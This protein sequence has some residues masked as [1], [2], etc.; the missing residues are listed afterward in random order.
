MSCKHEHKHVNIVPLVPLPIVRAALIVHKIIAMIAFSGR[1]VR[2]VPCVSRGY[3][4]SP[5]GVVC[6]V[7]SLLREVYGMGGN[8][9]GWRWRQDQ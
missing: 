6:P 3:C 7:P 1:L 4:T 9:N 2:S 8:V 5:F